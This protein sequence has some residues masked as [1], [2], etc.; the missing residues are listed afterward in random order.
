MP[1]TSRLRPN[2]QTSSFLLPSRNRSSIRSP[3]SRRSNGPIFRTRSA[4]QMPTSYRSRSRPSRTASGKQPS[5]TAGI[6]TSRPRSRETKRSERWFGK[7]RH[8]HTKPER[9]AAHRPAACS[10][11]LPAALSR[12]RIDRANAPGDRSRWLR[13]LEPYSISPVLYRS[14]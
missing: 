5:M 11:G 7:R 4:P 2:S 13:L 12:R 8:L 6:A 1:R 10:H 9:A 14:L 3:D